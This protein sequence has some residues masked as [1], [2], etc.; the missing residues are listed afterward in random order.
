MVLLIPDAAL[1]LLL[2]FPHRS[3]AAQVQRDG[4]V[5]H[6]RG[7]RGH[8]AE[9]VVPVVVGQCHAGDAVALEV[10]RHPG[11]GVRQRRAGRPGQHGGPDRVLFLPARAEVRTGRPPGPVL[12]RRADAQRQYPFPD[13]DDPGA[14][15]QFHRVRLETRQRRRQRADCPGLHLLELPGRPVCVRCQVHRMRGIAAEQFP[16]V[17]HMPQ[18]RAARGPVQRRVLTGAE[19]GPV[20]P[21]DVLRRATEPLAA[22]RGQDDKLGHRHSP[23]A[24]VDG[25]EATSVSPCH[26][27]DDNND[28]RVQS[29]SSGGG[30]P[31]GASPRTR[32]WPT[33][34]ATFTTSSP[35][36]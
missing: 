29:P 3:L 36:R 32:R 6:R 20:Q 5:D 14:L 10:G 17:L 19:R 30:R 18:A 26:A 35:R 8:R 11:H 16:P 4:H 28:L 13:A 23:A 22:A 21:G 7:L 2:E 33:P 25:P 24:P 15:G 12:R 34:G 1:Q 27:S 31:G 9:N